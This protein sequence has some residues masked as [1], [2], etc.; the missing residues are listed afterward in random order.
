[1]ASIVLATVGRAVG[2]AIAGPVGG[3]IGSTLGAQIGAGIDGGRGS[4]RHYEGARLEQLAVQSSLYGRMI[5]IVFGN[6]RLAGN[7]I[8]ARPLKELQTTT[9]TSQGGGKGG[10][11]KRKSTSTTTSY[12]YYATLAIAICEGTI[13]RISRVWADAKLLDL[14]QGTYRVY[15]G[16]ESQMPDA[17][18]ESF[19]GVG[20]TPAYRG[21]AYVVIEDFP[22]GDFGNR[23]PNF[24]FE[25]VRHVPQRDVAD[26]PVESMVQSIML[27][28]GS[29]EFVYDVQTQSKI[30]GEDASGNFVQQGYRIALNQHTA[31]GKAN[32]MVA[33]DQMLQ[34]FP[35]L[36]WV[37]V[38]VNWFGSSLDIGNCKISP[39]VEFKDNVAITPDTWSVAGLTRATAT[40][41]GKDS[42]VARYGGTPDDGS[43]I[44]LLNALRDRG[45]KIFFYPMMLMDMPGKPWRG[46]LTGSSADVTGFF[47]DPGGYN[48][49]ILHYANLVDGK[50]DAFAIGTEMRDLTKITSS[51]GVFPAVSQFVSLAASVRAILGSSVKLTYAADWSEYHHT[52]GGWYNLDPLWASPNID[53]VGIDAYFPLTNAV[54][55]N[56]DVD[57][58]RQGWHSGEGYDWYYTNEARTV[59]APL[60]PTYAWKNIAWWWSNPH[61]NPN[62]STTAWVPESKPI[63]FSEYGFAS[64]D[65]CANEP[66][67]FIDATS[68]ESA[69]PRFSR[70]RVD[71]M[72]QRAAIAATEAE[73]AGSLMVQ[74]KFLWTW[75]ARPYPY[76]PD[77]RSVWADG[78]NWATGHWVQG[79]LGSS[80]V[81]AAVERL[82]ER[83]G[84]TPSRLDT[85]ALQML[86]DGFVIHE[87]TTVRGA[88]SQLMQAFFFTLI[89]HEQG[90]TARLV[91]GGT[92]V[93]VDVGEC[94]PITVGERQVSYLLER[95]EDL[96]LPE[97]V[98][99]NYLNR[100]LRYETQ[101]QAA[102]RA[103]QSSRDT[104]SLRLG[105]VL[106]ESHARTVAEMQ[107]MRQWAERCQITVQ[108]PMRYAALEPGD[109]IY[110]HEG[111][112]TQHLRVEQVQ[113]GKPGILRV[114]ATRSEAQAWDGYIAPPED[115]GGEL[116]LP[117]A[118]T[119]LEVL[120]IPA[121]PGDAQDSCTL[122]LAACGMSAGWQGASI[123]RASGY[124]DDIAFADLDTPAVIGG[125][126]TAL[127]NAAPQ[128]IDYA[129]TLDVAL[130]GEAVLS[131]VS[132]PAM[133]DGANVAVVGNEIIQFAQA[134]ALGDGKYRL[135][136][137]LR[138]RLGTEP[139]CAG[140]S[141]GERFV[142]I[143]GSVVP[144]GITSASIGQTWNLNAVSIGS[145]PAEGS[146]LNH[147]VNG[148]SLKP[149][150]PVHLAARRV[151]GGDIIVSWVRR[152]RIDGAWRAAV[153][154]QLMEAREEYEVRI[155]SGTTMKR[156]WR[157]M[158][159]D[160]VYSATEQL[161]DFGSAPSS[162]T[163][164]VAQV[165]ALVGLGG[166]AQ[167]TISLT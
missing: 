163:L 131:S 47:T 41:V 60:S 29:G 142:L 28:P 57:A 155:M 44:R 99:V 15:K 162:I 80:H 14:S 32:M 67:V 12:S 93:T 103:T 55:T 43:I 112:N 141:A 3:H 13:T 27:I 125:C 26:E 85:S 158:G 17:L 165:S 111:A 56:Y 96:A 164:A 114:R 109:V 66:N 74:R 127:A 10:G 46:R 76:W 91:D 18:I 107:L 82:A 139:H 134:V 6:M 136:T 121:F 150:T 21:L 152:A 157:V 5:P 89:E 8:W 87:R 95:A 115:S 159:P 1:M 128:V 133:L 116:L 22:I 81:G 98:E 20:K 72:A 24:T 105:L 52:D 39:R 129:S 51:S 102:A 92:I 64:V 25:V 37:G 73:W 143:N 65:G 167:R 90:L 84:I 146:L 104:Q 79:K 16:T 124:G 78:V 53:I 122:R 130:L 50:V 160:H 117:P 135:S 7:V 126:L 83:V 149:Y 38:A 45:L 166:I 94:I 119:R 61:V 77:L 59:Q 110:L 140:H 113:L 86:L 97:R 145:S 31:E 138:G 40:L 58:I 144:L 88:L 36:E 69:F 34:T 68:S 120:D 108:L 70:G 54:Q 23:I 153:D 101:V 49:F 161:A 11:S 106:S 156:S 123:L 33:L 148:E 2:T 48:E 4:K 42:G 35:N 9:T 132:I 71:F 62:G 137:L 100:L 30:T 147:L 75:D 19:Q 118:L 151:A 63:W 154:V